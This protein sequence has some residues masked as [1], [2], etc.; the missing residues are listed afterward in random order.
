M[1]SAGTGRRR[2][3]RPGPTSSR[4][5]PTP[6][7][8]ATRRSW[9]KSGGETLD[10]ETV[11]RAATSLRRAR[12]GL[13]GCPAR[14]PLRCRAGGPGLSRRRASGPRAA[15]PRNQGDGA[16]LSEDGDLSLRLYQEIDL[17]DHPAS[18]ADAV[19]EIDIFAADAPR[20]GIGARFAEA[21]LELM[22]RYEIARK[23]APYVS[24]VT[25]GA[26]RDRDLPAGDGGTS[27]D[28]LPRWPQIL[29]LGER[30][31]FPAS[32]WRP[33]PSL[34]LLSPPRV[35][36]ARGHDMD[37]MEDLS[38]FGAP[39]DPAKADRTVA[40]KAIE[41]AFDTAALEIATGE[42]V[43]FVLTNAGTQD[44]E[45]RHRRRRLLR[46]HTKMMAD[47]PGMTHTMPNIVT[48]KPSETVGSPG[49]SQTWR[50]RVRLLDPRPLR[51]GHEGDDQRELA[52]P[53]ALRRMHSVA[54]RGGAQISPAEM[55][56]GRCIKALALL[57]TGSK[58]PEVS[59]AKRMINRQ[60]Q[61]EARLSLAE[62]SS[63]PRTRPSPRCSTRR[64]RR[65]AGGWFRDR[66]S[67]G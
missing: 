37:H 49:P 24:L 47:M 2:D 53:A 41:I 16:F 21:S 48:A 35:M 29:V 42:T 4:G 18:G 52:P 20:R 40:V 7:S 66:T 12:L 23:F 5:T 8:A 3:A 31:A 10:G 25:S 14:R 51:A 6:G 62:R 26:G 44:H 50:F 57:R 56:A 13:L 17:P 65:S 54:V 28:V 33:P 39:G 60:R 1:V 22:L 55:E 43:T 38:R 34:C 63:T 36:A 64:W 61:A 19:G 11:R 15:F 67:T 59:Y 9:L 30:H 46:R 32:C 27:D 45:V 58:G